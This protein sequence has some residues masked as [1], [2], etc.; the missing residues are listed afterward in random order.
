MLGIA[1]V[2][3]DL[4]LSCFMEHEETLIPAYLA[5]SCMQA[6]DFDSIA[7]VVE[8]ILKVVQDQLE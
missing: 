7:N 6:T 4:E 3:R 5:D 8:T 1:L 2:L